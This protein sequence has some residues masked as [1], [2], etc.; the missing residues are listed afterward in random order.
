MESLLGKAPSQHGAQEEDIDDLI[1]PDPK[2]TTTS[3]LPTYKSAFL[4]SCLNANVLTFGTFTL[5]SGKTS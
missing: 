2:P 1:P 3:T 5:K 4:Q